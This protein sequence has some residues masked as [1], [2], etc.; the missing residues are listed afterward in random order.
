M[1]SSQEKQNNADDS[2]NKFSNN[3][4]EMVESSIKYVE[5]QR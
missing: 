5:K 2:T 3:N 4:D 1:D